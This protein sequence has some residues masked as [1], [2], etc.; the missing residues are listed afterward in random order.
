MSH[1]HDMGMTIKNKLEKPRE[2]SSVYKR[3]VSEIGL[4]E[5]EVDELNGIF[6]VLG[7]SHFYEVNK[8]LLCDKTRY[9]F[10]QRSCLKVRLY[11]GF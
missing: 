1:R 9:L 3:Y 10:P 5:S 2:F 6:T 4:F 8:E 7:T 11:L